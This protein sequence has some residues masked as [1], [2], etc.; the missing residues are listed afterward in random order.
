[1]PKSSKPRKK[2]TPKPLRR[3]LRLPKSFVDSVHASWVKLQIAVE[4]KLRLG[5][6]TVDELMRTVDMFNLVGFSISRRSD[7]D[8]QEVKQF[9]E[10]FNRG[11]EV[12]AAVLRRANTL[13]PWRAVC[14]ADELKAVLS[15][16]TSVGEY[17][18]DALSEDA[19]EVL[20]NWVALGYYDF[21]EETNGQEGSSK[22]AE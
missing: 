19:A 10:V 3:K 8:E 20:N 2:H 18:N 5:E 1:M 6:C 17:L 13:T 11:A 14:T 9:E 16:L 7:Y 4:M 12:L 21:S 22:E 15:G